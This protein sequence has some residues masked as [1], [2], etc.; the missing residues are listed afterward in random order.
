M[1]NFLFA[2]AFSLTLFFGC[3]H[4]NSSSA[5]RQDLTTPAPASQPKAAMTEPEK[6]MDLSLT[7]EWS[8]EAGQL[9]LKYTV[10]NRSDK[11]YLLFNRGD[12]DAGLKESVFYIE[13]QPDGVVEI[14]QR[15]FTEPK[16]RRC[17]RREV[18]VYFGVSRLAAKQSVSG[19][20]VIPL[21][22]K[23]RA[24]YDD[25]A[26]QPVMPEKVTQVRFCLGAL[27]DTPDAASSHQGT[28]LITDTAL[29][30]QQ[31]LLCGEVFKF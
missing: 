6:N 5:P 1:P 30:N 31:K 4:K 21:P 10:T 11:S 2:V 26:P 7:T 15:A 20:L 18:P 12:M 25:C 28:L 22:L 29:M 24:P 23:Y 9:R 19:E 16:D 27:P 8:A 13:P 17:R 3:D 14:S